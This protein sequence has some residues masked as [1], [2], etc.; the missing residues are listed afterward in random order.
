MGEIDNVM[1]QLREAG[2]K[3]EIVE[4]D[5]GFDPVK[6]KYVCR[7]DSAG[8]KTGEAKKDKRLY[9]FRSIK[10]QVVEIIEGFKATNRFFDLV[11]N[12]DAD[13]VKRML[14]DLFSSGIDIKA[15][16]DEE[17]DMEL[18]TLKDKTMNIRA[19]VAPKMKKVGN[20][21]TKDDW[22]K[23]EP[24]ID[25]QKLKVVKDFAGNKKPATAKSN[26]PF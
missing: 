8:R 25:V 4:D 16:N 10:I 18:S 15:R 21:G 23:V 26:V 19:W 11:Y 22:Q 12:T 9:D 20:T 7:I 6:G 5:G 14:N 2:Y 24:R 3:P 17:L 1:Q 13:G